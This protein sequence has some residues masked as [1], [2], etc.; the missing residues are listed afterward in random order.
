MKLSFLLTAALFHLALFPCRAQNPNPSAALDNF[1]LSEMNTEHI[2]GMA[3]LVVKNGEIVWRQAYGMADVP[4][5]VA[6]TDSTAFLLASVSKLF[7]GTALM[8]LNEQGLIDLDGS[9]NDHLPFSIH[10]PNHPTVD[11]TFRMLM[12]H[13]SSIKDN[14][15]VMDGY[16]SVGDPTISLPDV[17]ERYFSTSGADYSV[18]GNFHSG[19]PGT[20]YDYSNMATALAGYLVEVISGT[21]FNEFCN[22]NIFNRLCMQ[23][24]SWFLA[25]FDTNRVARPHE[26]I[27]GQYVPY[28]HYGFADYP[29]GLLRSTTL[30]LANFMISYLQNGS[31]GGQQLLSSTSIGEMLTLQVSSLDDTQGLNW[32]Q[33]LVYLDGGGTVTVWGHNGGET[34]VSTDM[35]INPSNDIGIVVLSNA[36]GENLYVVDALYNYALSLQPTGEG[37][38]PCNQVS[39]NEIATEAPYN[40]Y[41]NP[42]TGILY[43]PSRESVRSALVLNAQG[44]L[45]HRSVNLP[46]STIDLSVFSDGLYLIRLEGE[47]GRTTEQRILLRK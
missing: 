26:W 35:Y 9:I 33:E 17:I 40:L 42:T 44:K 12:T 31:F 8:Q 38:P 39:V 25:D 43:L 28:A 11:I 22:A 19:A 2:P 3:T 4:N 47:N 41:P 23:N 36:E 14:G 21:P 45:M 7:V 30:D 15:N 27:S 13:T 29:D 5:S 16:Y 32:Y 10:N 34:G 6:T 1:I 20:V 37:N 18:Q 46:T 24:S